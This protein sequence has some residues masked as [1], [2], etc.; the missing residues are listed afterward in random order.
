LKIKSLLQRFLASTILLFSGTNSVFGAGFKVLPGHVPPIISG[1]TPTGNL[2]ATN[3]LLLAIGLPL[4][5]PE[6]LTNYLEQVYN[7]ASPNFRHFLTLAQFTE[8]FGPT[9]QDY[10]AVKQFAQSNGLSVGATYDNRLLLDVTGPAAAVEKAFNIKLRTYHHPTEGRDFFAPDREP[11]VGANLQVVD[12]QGL[13]NLSRPHSRLAKR[14]VTNAVPRSGSSPDGKGGYFGNDFR[15]AYAPG[16]TLTGAGQMLG[17]FEADGFYA[18]DIAAYAA[19]A[20]NGRANIVIQT[21]LLDGFSG[22]PTTGANSGNGEVSLDIEMAMAMAP[23]LAKIV[24]FEGN[25]NRFLQNDILNSML[26]YSN[27]VKNLSSSWGWPGGPSV[28]TDNIFISM[29]G[30]GQS[31]FSASGDS[32]A[33]TAGASSVNGVDNVSLN[34]A[35]SSSPYIT[36]VGGTTLTMNG[37]GA[38]FKSETVW[39]WGIEIG[40]QYDGSGSSGG[41]SSY[42]PIPSWQSSVSNLASAGGSTSFRNIPDVALTAD[43]IYVVSGGSA[44]GTD[45]TGGTSCAAPLWAAFIA[46]VNEQ[47]AANGGQSV[48]F[49]NPALYAIAAGPNYSTCFNDVTTGNNTWSSST[50]LFYAATGYDLCTGLGS[51]AGQSLLNALAGG[52]AL[53]VSPLSDSATG[54]AG[55]PFTLASGSFVLTN[56]SSSN[57]DWSLINSPT[58]LSISPTNGSLAAGSQTT[59]ACSLTAAASNLTVGTYATSLAFSN[60]TVQ[61]V[62]TVP[63]TL[64]VNQPMVISPTNGFTASGPG[65]GPFSLSSQTYTL[66]NQGLNPVDWSLLNVPSWLS[67]APSNGTLA[68]SGQT[69][70]TVSLSAAASNLTSGN[71][72][73]TVIATNQFGPAAGLSFTLGVNPSLVN[74]GDFE[75]GSF[76]GWT[77]TG[78][79]KYNN[80]TSSSAFVHSGSYGAEFGTSGS[81]AYLRQTVPTSA[82]QN[83]LLSLWLDNPNNSHG[84]TPNQFLIQWNG[85]TIFNRTNIP[86]T[87]WTNL[88]FFVTATGASTVLQFGFEDNPNYLGLDDV[89]LTPHSPPRF[90]AARQNATG[91]A[92]GW[93]AVPNLYYQIQY[94]TNLLQT[95]W[96]NLGAPLLATTNTLTFLDTNATSSAPSRFYRILEIP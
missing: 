17:L 96:L 25:P 40:S 84:A 58:W 78:S 12:I 28:T 90:N 81:L 26:S 33:F 61:A 44:V 42:Y 92:L 77:L 45:N 4:R 7:P 6:A 69:S 85:A 30:V 27:T 66:S 83:Y 1:L 47:V 72:S 31:F 82:G 56:G 18:N 52:V 13:S 94:N 87:A 43:N 50:S 93:S 11:Q 74:N 95:N 53:A 5:S 3:E 14:D 76:T 21:V 36:E 37:T 89:S 20:G 29:A 63:F 70:F 32:C 48:G 34:N 54:V 59:L 71:Y 39:N 62:E 24:V 9:E 15:N 23:G 64:Q 46:L 55:G 68:T 10:K 57:L 91:F 79:T 49:V 16:V 80:V 60:L 41:V 51:P 8:Q 38:S 88:Q 86:F 2:A 73:A 22:T 75:T 35:P 65:G 19:A 67:V